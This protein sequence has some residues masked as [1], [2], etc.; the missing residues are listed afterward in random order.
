MGKEDN[1][2]EKR[3]ENIPVSLFDGK[4]EI[5]KINPSFDINKYFCCFLSFPCC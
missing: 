4:I 5:K 1:R 3:E 2:K